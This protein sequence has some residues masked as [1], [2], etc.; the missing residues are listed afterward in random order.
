M[1]FDLVWSAH[2]ADATTINQYNEDDTENKFQEVLDRQDHLIG[3]SLL[4]TKTMT[5]YVV[6]IKRGCI[7]SGIGNGQSFLQ[8]REDMIRKEEYSY[9]LIYFREVER[10]FGNSLQEIEPPKVLYFLGYQYTDSNGKNHKHVMKI[11]SDG[12]FVII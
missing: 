7:F 3:F 8:P 2:F 6:D 10:T 1:T 9:R 5:H 4:N 12:R 11:H